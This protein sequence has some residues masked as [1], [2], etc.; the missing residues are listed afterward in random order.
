MIASSSEPVLD[1]TN[2]LSS[3]VSVHPVFLIHVW[4]SSVLVAVF[5]TSVTV[6]IF[7]FDLCTGALF[8]A[9]S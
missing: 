6:I 3:L 5:W 8:H 9:L 2:L 7:G 4:S 1:I